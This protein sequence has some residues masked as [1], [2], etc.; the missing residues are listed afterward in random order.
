MR[1][2]KAM[3]LKQHVSQQSI[4]YGEN[5]PSATLRA[6]GE[7]VGLMAGQMGDSN[8]GHLNIGAGRIVYQDVAQFSKAIKEGEFFKNEQLLKA[9]NHA[10]ENSTKLHLMGLVSPG[11]VH[12]H[13]MHLYA[14]LQMAKEHGCKMCTSMLFSTGVM[15]PF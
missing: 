2:K 14:L 7:S 1:I 13:S 11:G 12:S 4:G 8:V 3:Q 5:C 15:S 6:S 10:K 9:I